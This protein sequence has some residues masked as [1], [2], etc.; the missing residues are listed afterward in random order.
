MVFLKIISAV[1]T[2]LPGKVSVELLIPPL[3]KSYLHSFFF[4]PT[5]VLAVLFCSVLFLNI[6]TT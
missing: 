5:N 6:S 4:F 2:V 1:M 3:W